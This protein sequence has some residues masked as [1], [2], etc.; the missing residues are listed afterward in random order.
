MFDDFAF[1]LTHCL[2][3]VLF[4]PSLE[5]Y[6]M[7]TP[8][9]DRGRSHVISWKTQP[10]Q[11]TLWACELKQCWFMSVKEL[12]KIQIR[13]YMRLEYDRWF[14]VSAI[15][16]MYSTNLEYY[17]LDP[18]DLANCYPENLVLRNQ[19]NNWFVFNLGSKHLVVVL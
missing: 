17:V 5:L 9:K 7:P 4:T 6:A 13:C 18:N 12:L 3:C 14:V 15:N 19:F 1:L 11:E 10:N 8:C 16:I 2:F